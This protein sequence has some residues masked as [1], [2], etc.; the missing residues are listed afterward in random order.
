MTKVIL[1]NHLGILLQGLKMPNSV[2]LAVGGLWYENLTHNRYSVNS[3]RRKLYEAEVR[4][5]GYFHIG[6]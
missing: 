5:R 6:S 4:L 3:E 1:E 2:V